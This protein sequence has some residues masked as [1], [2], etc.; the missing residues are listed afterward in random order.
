MAGLRRAEDIHFAEVGD[1]YFVTLERRDVVA[2]LNRPAFEVL[3]SLDGAS[4]PEAVAEAFAKARGVDPGEY[5]AAVQELCDTALDA[6]LLVEAEP[7]GKAARPDVEASGSSELPRV[8][9][10]WREEDLADGMF[11]SSMSDDIHVIVPNV[12]KGPI[13]TCPP[14][15]CTIPAGLFTTKTIIKTFGGR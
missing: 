5:A 13:T 12:T 15:T 11:V 3:E 6:G 10:L 7:V 4:A 1:E 2:C 8:V 14:H 9:D